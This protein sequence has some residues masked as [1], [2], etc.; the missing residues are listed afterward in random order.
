MRD[1]DRDKEGRGGDDEKARKTVRSSEEVRE[2]WREEKGRVNR[3]G[4]REKGR[5]W[6]RE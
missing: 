5:E 1:N 4:G 2:G 6:V 3:E